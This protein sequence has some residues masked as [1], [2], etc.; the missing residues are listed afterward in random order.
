MSPLDGVIATAL[1]AASLL[2]AYAGFS[3]F[4]RP[5]PTSSALSRVGL[6]SGT[7]TARILGVVEIVIAAGFLVAGGWL[8][9]SALCLVHLAFAAFSLRLRR[10]D[11]TASCGCFGGDTP[12]TV[13]HV[14]VNILVGALAGVAAASAIAAG[15]G[16]PSPAVSVLRSSPWEPAPTALALILAVIVLHTAF[17]TRF[18][19]PRSTVSAPGS[20]PGR[21]V[22]SMLQG[23]R[24]PTP[25]GGRDRGAP[26][27]IPVSGVNHVTALVFLSTTCLVC[28]GIWEELGRR[29]GPGVPSAIRLF[30]VVSAEDDPARL[31]GLTPPGVETVLV[32]DAHRRW[33]VPGDPWVMLLDGPSGRVVAEGT[34]AGWSDLRSRL[35]GSGHTGLFGWRGRGR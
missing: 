4:L 8:A 12:V 33:G 22:P 31:A 10:D 5:R 26:V 2:L 7:A 15:P 16:D 27:S 14:P 13:L 24:A 9:A 21:T 28:R 1:T 29:R 32:E 3:K 30:I 17:T 23:E 20:E 18:G 35:V 11:P 25:G 34:G 6:P 19:A